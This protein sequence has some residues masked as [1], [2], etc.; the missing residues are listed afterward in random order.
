MFIL[1]YTG[2]AS[3]GLCVCERERETNHLFCCWYTCMK[4]FQ[5]WRRHSVVQKEKAFTVKV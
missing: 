4:E 5:L 2:V 3:L 1:L